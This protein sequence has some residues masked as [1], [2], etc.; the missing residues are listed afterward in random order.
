MSDDEYVDEELLALLRQSL[1]N[2]AAPT[3]PAKNVVLEDAEFIYDNSIDVAIDM[4]GTKAA[5]ESIYDRMQAQDFSPRSWAERP[6]HPKTKNAAAIDFIFTM[7]LLNFSFWP[8]DPQGHS[9]TVDYESKAWT[10]YSSLLA[11]LWRAIAEG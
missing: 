6:L 9:F 2:G 5:A 4:A 7:D 1:S 11:V 8:D 10:G 3:L